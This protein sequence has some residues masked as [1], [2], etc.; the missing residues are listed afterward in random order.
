MIITL[1]DGSK[2]N[3]LKQSP[4]LRLLLISAR[5]WQGL[6]VREKWTEKWWISAQ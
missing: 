2:K 3:I 5:A 6:H 4:C 1:K